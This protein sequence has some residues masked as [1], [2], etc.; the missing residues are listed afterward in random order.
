MLTREFSFAYV[1]GQPVINRTTGTEENG[2]ETTVQVFFRGDFEDGKPVF[3]GKLMDQD[4]N[5]HGQII[6]S[7]DIERLCNSFNSPEFF[8]Q[9]RLFH[10]QS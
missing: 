6:K 4:G 10:K 9:D 1:D 2:I 3:C 7:P 8:L 5:V